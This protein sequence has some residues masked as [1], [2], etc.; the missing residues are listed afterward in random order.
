[1]AIESLTDRIFSTQSDV[2]SFGVLLWEL[3]SLGKFPYPGMNL[4]RLLYKLQKGYRMTK[5]AFATNDIG[6]LM[7]DCWN[8][9]PSLRPTFRDLEISL[10]SQLEASLSEDYLF[11]DTFDPNPTS[12]VFIS[13]EAAC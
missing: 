1:M 2:W 12:N 4:D 7:I 3:F 5:P 10:S 9:E 8:A 11:L 13:S 6:Q